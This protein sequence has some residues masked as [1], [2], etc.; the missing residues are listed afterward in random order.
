MAGLAKQRHE[1]GTD[2]PGRAGDSYTHREDLSDS[3]PTPRRRA[4][5]PAGSSTVQLQPEVTLERGIREA[6][7]DGV[8]EPGSIGAVYQPVIVGQ[9]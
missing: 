3:A 7:L 9:G 2:Q 4:T 1:S 8:E 6:L 5:T